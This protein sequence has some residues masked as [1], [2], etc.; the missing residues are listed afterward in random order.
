MKNNSYICRMD[1]SGI[2]TITNLIDNK[3]YVGYATNFR[4]RKA[5]HLSDLRKNKHKNIH[6]QR[7]FNRGGESNF[8]CELIEECPIELL[9]S[10]ENY[11]SNLLNSH[12]P[13]FG[14]NILPTS[15]VG[16]IT[17][18]QETREKLSKSHLGKKLSQ[19]T[20]EK[21]RKVNTGR[22]HTEDAKNNM[23]TSLHE[24]IKQG[25]I[26]LS[27]IQVREIIGLINSGEKSSKIARKYNVSRWTIANIKY[28]KQWKFI[29]KG[30]VKQ[31]K[32]R[33]SI[34]QIQQ[35]KSRL[36]N[37]IKVREISLEL[38]I[39]IG[40]IYKIKARPNYGM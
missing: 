30:F 19:E 10:M 21:I 32:S 38:N 14:Y 39:P 36:S 9:P 11:W 1:K 12:N 17:H 8:V 2:Y 31:N 16:I 25:S 18:S 34:E 24:N 35:V 28:D 3:I 15:N 22:K 20:I 5:A 26:K 23:K 37:N 7:A 40:I 27:E 13:K 29:D 4:K 33:Y 6:L